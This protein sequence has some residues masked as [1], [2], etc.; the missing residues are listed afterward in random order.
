MAFVGADGV[1]LDG[2]HFGAGYFPLAHS[3]R[4]ER[5]PG[6]KAV[7]HAGILDPRFGNPYRLISRSPA[8]NRCVLRHTLFG[9]ATVNDAAA[10]PDPAEAIATQLADALIQ[11]QATHPDWMQARFREQSL[12]AKRQKL[13]QKLLTL[14][15]SSPDANT[16]I[17][18]VIELL[19][20]L[21]EPVVSETQFYPQVRHLIA[22]ELSTSIVPMH[23]QSA[24]W[25][26]ELH[27]DLPQ[28]ESNAQ[29]IAILLLD[30]EN[31]DLSPDAEAWLEKDCIYP[32]SLK[33]AFGNWKKLGNRDVD[34][35]QRGYQLLHVPQGKN[36]ADDKMTM[37]GSSILVHLPTIKAAIVCS[38]D[39]GLENLRHTLRF[40]GL[41]VSLLQRHQHTLKLTNCKTKQS[42][43]LTLPSSAQMPSVEQ[44]IQYCTTYL[45]DTGE[46][47]V[48]LSQLS[49]AF[50]KD[51][52]FP[53]S[54]F[55]KHHKLAKTP[56]AFFQQ[57]T[58]F[59]VTADKGNSQWYVSNCT[60]PGSAKVGKLDATHT[61]K[62][63]FTISTLGCV[64]VGIAKH[65]IRQQDGDA[66]TV[67]VLATTFHQQYGQSM[68]T[69]L[70]KLEQEPSV[71]KFLQTCQGLKVYQEDNQWQV[72]L[73]A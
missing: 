63:E 19:T 14:L 25:Q 67:G 22:T 52:G 71:P 65:L 51:L 24:L 29:A 61:Q 10:N 72:A 7:L 59:R 33:F 62:K 28:P 17:D 66:V 16:A 3:I 12:A 73:A 45:S 49:S 68:K 42:T 48:L 18:Q 47:K 15:Q 54:A 55:V 69:L 6:G 39:N 37:I 27:R 58:Q 36:H 46:P 9:I 21:L 2:C 43:T 40:Q 57:S 32:L 30:A 64:C 34:L 23:E 60:Q 50:S 44:G 5:H 20:Q 31:I 26:P 8:G 1:G 4:R 38:N 53:I 70:E 11:L 41:D 56:K 35:H 13:V